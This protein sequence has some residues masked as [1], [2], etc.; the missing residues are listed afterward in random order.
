MAGSQ[1]PALTATTK[2]NNTAGATDVQT[3]AARKVTYIFQCTTAASV[4]LPYAAV[5][6]GKVIPAHEKRVSRVTSGATK[7]NGQTRYT[8]GKFTI[9]AEAGDKVSLYLNSDAAVGH[10]TSPVYA[11][12]V[13]ERDIVVKVTEKEGLLSDGDTPTMVAKAKDAKAAPTVDEYTA[14]LTGNVWMKVSH[15]YT[16]AEVDALMPAG[17]K[18]EVIAAIKCI[19][20]ELPSATLTVSVPAAGQQAAKSLTVTFIDSNNPKANIVGYTL[21]KEGLTRVHPGGFAALLNSALENGIPSLQVT[22]CWRPMLGSIA[23][24]AGLGLD[25]GY[26]GLTRMNRQELRHAFEGKKPSKNG[27]GDDADNVSDA[28]VETFAEYES[29]IVEAKA[30]RAKLSAAE[31]A[32][33]AAK[34][35]KDSTKS[36]EAQ[37]QVKTATKASEDADVAEDKARNAWNDE[38]DAAEPAD[39]RLFR[40]S[41]LKCSCVRQ[42]FD[43]WVMD[44]NTQDKT[45]PAPNMQRGGSSSNERLHAH[46]LH[47]TVHEPTIL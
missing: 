31:K 18:A 1:K 16:A 13:G 36:A 29:A 45:T 22:S 19:Y 5:V 12:T 20:S 38:R 35:T 34:K 40:T 21:L 32:L 14:A 4:S 42:L 15:K 26:V 47:I 46:H 2:P 8:E 25:V 43:P 17:T 37:S 24:R 30:A 39:A 23:H 33:V 9:D 28:E 11:V 44:A 7:S 41:L 6:N 10:R 27:N 3:K